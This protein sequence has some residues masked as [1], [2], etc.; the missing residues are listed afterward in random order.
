[1][2]NHRCSSARVSTTS[3]AGRARR[4]GARRARAADAL[5]LGLLLAGRSGNDRS[6]ASRRVRGPRSISASARCRPGRPGC[7]RCS[8]VSTLLNAAYFLPLLY[9]LWFRDPAPDA[10]GDERA[11]ALVV[12][13]VIAALAALGAG[14]LAA[15]A[16]SPLGWAS[17][18]AEREYLRFDPLDPALFLPLAA[19]VWPLL[20]A[21]FM[22]VPGDPDARGASPAAGAAPGP[23]AGPVGDRGHD[24]R[25]EPPAGGHSGARAGRASAPRHGAAALLVRRGPC[26]R[27]PCPAGPT[28]RSSR[29]SGA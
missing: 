27:N 17:L 24:D 6:A 29:A 11:P 26:P 19:L 15:S 9:R 14:G 22:A 1:M 7:L 8:G 23:L 16:V 10:R 13:A 3:A 2:K 28:Q 12:P 18:I 25:A 5:D 20:L 21:A 4:R